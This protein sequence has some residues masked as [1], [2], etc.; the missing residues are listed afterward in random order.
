MYGFTHFNLSMSKSCTR[1]LDI[2]KKQ[3]LRKRNV[4]LQEFV[5]YFRFILLWMINLAQ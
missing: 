5:P 3:F 2:F 4:T 1:V